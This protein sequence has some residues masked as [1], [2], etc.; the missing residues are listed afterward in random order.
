MPLIRRVPKRG[1]TNKFATES[2]VLNV[3]DLDKYDEGTVVTPE[4]LT[5]EGRMPKAGAKLRILGK[6]DV[7][8]KLVVQAHHVS[9]GA[10]AKIEA[11]GGRVEVL[12]A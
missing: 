12:P 4:L 7:K 9:K 5:A 6:G 11:V 2:V 3:R 8:K 1:F 10:K